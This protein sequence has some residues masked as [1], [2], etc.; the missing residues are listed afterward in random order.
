MIHNPN[1]KTMKQSSRGGAARADLLRATGE[2]IRDCTP[3]V[4]H[5]VYFALVIFAACYWNTPQALVLLALKRAR[6]P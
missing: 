2:L 1:R 6:P 3:L 5:L 4:V